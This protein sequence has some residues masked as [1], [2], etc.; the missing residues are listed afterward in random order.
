M[1]KLELTMA[2]RFQDIEQCIEE[3]EGK[4]ELREEIQVALNQ[5]LKA[6]VGHGETLQVCLSNKIAYL[7]EEL[8]RVV[9]KLKE[10]K[11]ALLET[12][13]EL[14]LCKRAIAQGGSNVVVP[15]PTKVD[16]PRPKPFHGGRTTSC[17]AWN[18]IF[19]LL[20]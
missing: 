10:I 1:A 8:F 19:M 20:V 18:N 13:D 16:V 12:K 5:V 4:D 6:C 15:T 11:N 17:G 2:D 7:K 9:G 3:L 14:V